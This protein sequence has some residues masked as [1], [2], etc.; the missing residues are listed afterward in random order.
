[1]DRKAIDF[2]TPPARQNHCFPKPGFEQMLLW[3][4]RRA[5]F[6]KTASSTTRVC[7]SAL[8]NYKKN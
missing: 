2:E 8:R 4:E 5:F 1:L 3:L 7:Q 6:P